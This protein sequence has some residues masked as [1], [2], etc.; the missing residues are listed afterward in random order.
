MIFPNDFN[1]LVNYFSFCMWLFHT[2]TCF[3]VIIF[4]HTRP[5]KQYPRVFKVWQ[6]F[7]MRFIFDS[8]SIGTSYYNLYC[9]V[10]SDC[11]SFPTG[12]TNIVE[13]RQN[14]NSGIWY[15]ICVCV[16][17]DRIRV[18]VAGQ[19]ITNVWFE[20]A[21]YIIHKHG[22]ASL[23]SSTRRCR[24]RVKE[25]LAVIYFVLPFT[26]SLLIQFKSIL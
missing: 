19:Y 2:A 23:P 3:T 10:L 18:S 17:L 14:F 25:C 22:A 16:M 20:R 11:S 12:E 7:G 1:S 8:G 5:V 4:R 13:I 24:S 6:E 26:S 15:G 21:T 9:W